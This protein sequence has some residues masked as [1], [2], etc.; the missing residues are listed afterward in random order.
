M[1]RHSASGIK[2]V[3]KHTLD[4]DFAHYLAYSGRWRES[5]EIVALLREAFEAAWRP[6]RILDMDVID[7][8]LLIIFVLVFSALLGITIGVLD[9]GGDMVHT[10]LLVVAFVLFLLAAVGVQHPRVNFVALGLALW[11]LTL[12]I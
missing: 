7:K 4:E 11:I 10:I 8:A 12:I 2:L 5:A 9:K 3:V 1:K 6:E